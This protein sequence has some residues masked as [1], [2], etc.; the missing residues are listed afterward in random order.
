MGIVEG[1]TEFLPVSSTGHLILAGS[2]LGF[3]DDKSKVFDI[4][5]QTGAIFAVMIVYAQRLRE[6]PMP[7]QQPARNTPAA[8][9]DILSSETRRTMTTLKER[10]HAD[11]VSHMKD[12][13][14]VALTTVR[15]VLGEIET[16]EK[17]HFAAF[18]SV[19]V[20][21]NACLHRSHRRRARR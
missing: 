1:L 2:L 8:Y 20:G 9:A 17:S 19:S 12:R 10:L 3:S 4:A 21:E 11:V 18:S 15:N 14:K 7:G 13:N 5:I 16:R 6:T